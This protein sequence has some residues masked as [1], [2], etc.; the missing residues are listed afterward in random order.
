MRRALPKATSYLDQ[1]EP[2]WVKKLH[3]RPKQRRQGTTQGENFEETDTSASTRK[4]HLRAKA[5]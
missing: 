3:V 2:Q 1:A 5:R 4:A